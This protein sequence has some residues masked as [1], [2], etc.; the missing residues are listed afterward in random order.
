MPKTVIKSVDKYLTRM[1][2]GSDHKLEEIVPT[3][4][5]SR[6]EVQADEKDEPLIVVSVV[7]ESDED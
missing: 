1:L 3:G 6:I 2:S 7:E 5:K 4:K